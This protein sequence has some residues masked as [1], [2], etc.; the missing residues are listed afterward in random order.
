MG[1]PA[2][3]GIFTYGYQWRMPFSKMKKRLHRKAKNIKERMAQ[4]TSK[5]TDAIR[6]GLRPIELCN[7]C[8]NH[9]EVKEPHSVCSVS[10][11]RTIWQ[12][13]KI[14]INCKQ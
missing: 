8:D 2:L 12:L 10:V 1:H 6:T 7:V 13:L 14:Y 4:E 11:T 9:E 3:Q 5:G